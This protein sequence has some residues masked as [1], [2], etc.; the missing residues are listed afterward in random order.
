MTSWTSLFAYL[1]LQTGFGESCVTVLDADKSHWLCEDIRVPVF[2]RGRAAAGPSAAD[3]GSP[4]LSSPQYHSQW[5]GNPHPVLPLSYSGRRLTVGY[6]DTTT[7]KLQPSAAAASW[8]MSRR[9]LDVALNSTVE[10][11][12]RC[13][14]PMLSIAS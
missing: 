2:L 7:L 8:N 5:Q 4:W 11:E 12:A 1:R 14:D 3:F 6:L 9:R 13:V 10:V